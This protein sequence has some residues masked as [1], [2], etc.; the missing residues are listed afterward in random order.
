MTARQQRLRS[1]AAASS[2]RAAALILRSR[3]D[4]SWALQHFFPFSKGAIS[5][6]TPR[7][8]GVFLKMATRS[9]VSGCGRSLASSDGHDRCLSCYQHAE[10]ALVDESWSHCGNM[11]IAML[12]S[13]NLL[14]DILLNIS[15][16]GLLE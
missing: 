11:T 8:T 6:R 9:C 12:R 14:V 5:K 3:C 13:R 4:L 15:R 7:A 1:S 10:A 2:E 16:G